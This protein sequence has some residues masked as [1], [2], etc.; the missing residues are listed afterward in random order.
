MNTAW[1][2]VAIFV[3]AEAIAYMLCYDGDDSDDDDD[4]EEG[5]GDGDYE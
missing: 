1:I 5:D 4:D 3:V 2:I